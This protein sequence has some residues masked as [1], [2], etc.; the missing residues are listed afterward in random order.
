MKMS[1]SSYVTAVDRAGTVNVSHPPPPEKPKSTSL[2][3]VEVTVTVIVT[4]S[5]RLN[6]FVM[7]AAVRLV[8]V[9]TAG[10]GAE[11]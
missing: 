6:T 3:H 9:H 7:P 1:L 5:Y 10:G 8:D 2:S 11:P 4:Q